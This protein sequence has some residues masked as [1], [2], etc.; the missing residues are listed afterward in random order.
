MFQHRGRFAAVILAIF[1]LGPVAV[2][3]QTGTR[4]IVRQHIQGPSG[5]DLLRYGLNNW[6]RSIPG[7]RAKAMGGAGL[8]IMQGVD[9]ASLNPALWAFL[10]AP[11]LSA[12]SRYRMGGASSQRN[13]GS[14]LSPDGSSYPTRDYRPN[15]T[16]N[17]TYNDLSYGMPILFFGRRAGLGLTYR[18]LIDFRSGDEARFVVQSPFGSADFGAGTQFKGGLDAISPSL[19]VA[20]NPRLAVGLTANFMTGQ[21]RENGDEGVTVFGQVVSRGSVYLDQDLG[22]TSVDLGGLFRP[23][24][25]LDLAATLQLGHSVDFTNG[26]DSRESLPDPSAQNPPR[27]IIER[28]LLDHSLDVPTM[29]GLGASWRM[30]DRKVLLAA[31]YWLR[32]WDKAEYTRR[33]FAT[34]TLFPDSNLLSQTVTAVTPLSGEV[35]RNANLRDSSHMRLGLEWMAVGT[36]REGVS[37]PI[38]IGFRSEPMAVAAIDTLGYFLL[39][40]S[41]NKVASNFALPVADR[42]QAIRGLVDQIYQTGASLLSGGDMKQTVITVGTGIKVDAFSIDL[43]LS[44]SSYTVERIFLGSFNDLT[45]NRRTQSAREKRSLTEVSITA[46]LRF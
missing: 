5:A 9:G 11:Q 17:Y 2:H 25:N 31:D 3:A 30:F 42:K 6:D 40:D 44:R 46:G 41:I 39:A 12:E 38:R 13:P 8:A 43:A 28:D 18:R 37:I 10:P 7:A 26:R 27:V 20:L 45:L 24:D 15:V 16:N 23:T 4:E 19:G 34:T 29:V 21:I 1:S 14:I 22:G 36:G 33:A 32:P 35:T